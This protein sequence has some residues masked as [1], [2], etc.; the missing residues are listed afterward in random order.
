MARTS[1]YVVVRRRDGA[2]RIDRATNPHPGPVAT[3][4][5][6]RDGSGAAIGWKLHPFLMMHG[7][8]S[9]TWQTPAEA[10]ASTKLM[11][12][13]QARAAIGAADAAGG[14]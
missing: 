1:D 10:V 7:S 5:P 14:P 11:T 13:G 3:I 6:S 4:K 9:K 2:Y 12:P 8:K